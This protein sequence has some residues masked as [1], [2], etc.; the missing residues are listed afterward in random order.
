M[1][2]TVQAR[3]SIYA[4]T[5]LPNIDY[6]DIFYQEGSKAELKKIQDIETKALKLC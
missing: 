5:V 1:V 4:T 2:F 6:D 3:L